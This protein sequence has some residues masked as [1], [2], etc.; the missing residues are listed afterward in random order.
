MNKDAFNDVIKNKLKDYSRPVAEDSWDEIEK[1]LNAKSGKKVRLW[2]WISGMAVAASIALMWIIFSFN[3]QK[4]IECYETATELPNHEKTTPTDVFEGKSVLSDESSSVQIKP[5]SV[6]QKP[7]AGNAGVPV[8]PELDVREVETD[9][10]VAEPPEPKEKKRETFSFPDNVL[11]GKLVCIASPNKKKT[12]SFGLHVGSGGNLLAMNNYPETFS[13][14]SKPDLMASSKSRDLFQENT[15]DE[16]FSPDNFAEI[17]HHLPLSFGLS[18][19]KELNDYFSVESGLIY[20]YLYSTFENKLPKRD[21]TVG[22]HYLGIPVNLVANLY[23]NNHSNWNIYIS[24]GGI[25]EKGLVSHRVQNSYD[26]N[27]RK[28]SIQSN[29][30]I[31]GLQWSVNAAIGIDYKI[32]KNYSIYFEPQVNYYLDNNQPYTIRAEHPLVFGLN[33]GLRYSW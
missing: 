25:V 7:G 20:T 8:L 5:V 18:F 30:K 24:A 12:K 2:P 23:H 19:R 3:E 4:Q 17:T 1:R 28:F 10:A 22:L 6:R 27:N 14:Y 33:A 21:A 32:I 13:D 11:Q 15:T 16:E 29:E 26:E 9:L 31:D